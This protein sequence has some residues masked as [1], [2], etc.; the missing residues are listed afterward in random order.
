MCEGVIASVL[1]CAFLRI[2]VCGECVS[3]NVR[4]SA[5]RGHHLHVCHRP[6]CLCKVRTQPSRERD[7][8]H[9]GFA[10][11]T[12]QVGSQEQRLDTGSPLASPQEEIF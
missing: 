3:A 11:V 8:S 4:A 5:C 6:E 7:G 9:R 12:F 10:F 2:C 1:V